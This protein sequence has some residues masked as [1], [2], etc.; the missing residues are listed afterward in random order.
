MPQMLW[1]DN[2]SPNSPKNLS[3]SL[4]NTGLQIK[5]EK[6]TV[7]TSELE[8]IRGYVL[9]RFADNETVDITNSSAIR[10]II[11]KDTTA[12]LDTD[13]SRQ[14]IRYTYVLTAFDRLHNESLA[15]NTSFVAMVTGNEDNEVFTE[16]K[17]NQNVP[18][19]FD[20]YTKIT[21]K[22]DKA[23][24]VSIKIFD[25]T[26]FERSRLVD[27]FKSAGE[28]SYD[29]YN[30]NL[31]TGVYFYTLQTQGNISVKRIIVIR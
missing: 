17:L 21:Y 12:F 14:A 31:E 11:Y 19:P 16:A 26:G 15:S 1:K 27:E 4:T 3:A 2:I 13:I 7:G 25:I 28:Y 8:K 10:S 30:L 5:W 23:S 29:F 9:Y 18:N 22:L 20:D 24:H 6:P